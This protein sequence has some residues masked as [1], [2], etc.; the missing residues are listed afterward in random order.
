MVDT[1]A[2]VPA[3]GTPKY[4]RTKAAAAFLGVAVG[5]MNNQRSR[6]VGVPFHKVNGVIWYS[7]ADLTAY[8]EAGRVQTRA[9]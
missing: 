1:T 9:A 7:L 6:R 2:L 8:V 3:D 5:T 4:L